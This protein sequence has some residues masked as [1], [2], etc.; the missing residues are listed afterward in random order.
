MLEMLRLAFPAKRTPQ[1]HITE[2]GSKQVCKTFHSAR[3][4]IQQG[5]EPRTVVALL[6]GAAGLT[7]AWRGMIRIAA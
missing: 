2:G 3:V 6:E 4:R 5:L 1:W 7:A